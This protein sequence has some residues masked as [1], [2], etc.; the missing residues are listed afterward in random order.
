VDKL[1]V[2]GITI[3]ARLTA[4]DH[5]S[6][7]LSSCSSLLYTLRILRSHGISDASLQDVFR[8]TV[9][10]KLTYCSPAWSGYCSAADLSRLV[11]FKIRIW[12]IV[13]KLP[14]W[15]ITSKNS[16]FNVGD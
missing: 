15:G 10:A 1:T 4:N 9:L 7:L 6:G 5:V 12:N 13:D 11:G 8:A 16:C 14:M 2:F 3:N